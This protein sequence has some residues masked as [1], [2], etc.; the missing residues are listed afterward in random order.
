M[1]KAILYTHDE[2]WRWMMGWAMAVESKPVG[3]SADL[4][5]KRQV[6]AHCDMEVIGGLR[7]YRQHIATCE[8]AKERK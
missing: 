4:P 5:N 3:T 6:C 1:F 7:E 8:K 2:V